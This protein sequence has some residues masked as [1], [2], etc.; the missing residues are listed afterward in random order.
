MQINEIIAKG[1]DLIREGRL[2]EAQEQF[3]LVLQYDP[4]NKEAHN[5]LGF[6][7]F[8]QGYPE[9][10]LLYFRNA[11]AIDPLYMDALLNY[12]HILRS[13]NW[14]PHAVPVLKKAVALDPECAELQALLGEASAETGGDEDVKTVSRPGAGPTVRP[15]RV[16]HLPLI[17]ANNAITLSKH[18]QHLGVES[19]VIS[20]FRTW[21]GYRG[22]F[23]LDLDDLD[24]VERQRRVRTFV[25]DFLDHEAHKYDIFHFHFFD[26]LSTGTSLGG[27]KSHPERDDFWDLERIKGMGKRI[28]VSSWGSDVRNN[29]KLVY[30]QLKYEDPDIQLPYPPLN[31][32]EQY[33][34]IWKFAQYADAMVHGDYETINHTPWGMMI[35]I[36]LDLEPFD[37]LLKNHP[38]KSDRMSILYAP[39][40]QFYKGT[41]YAEALLK[42]ITACYGDAVEIR[43]IHGLPYEEAIKRYVGWGAAIDDIASFSFGLF[44]LEAMY[45]GRTVFTTLRKEEYFGDDMKLKAPIV[46]VY[47]EE[48]FYKKM[49]R[50]IDGDNRDLL[51]SYQT[52][53][54]ERCAASVIARRYQVL[55]EQLMAGERIEQF[56]SQA[57]NRE[58]NNFINGQKVDVRDYYPKVTDILLK[59]KDYGKLMHE[60]EM[61]MGLSNDGDLV[62]KYIFAKEATDQGD[63]ALNLRRNNAAFVATAA[64]REYYQRARDLA[65]SSHCP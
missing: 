14:L 34:N 44:T 28:V 40:N 47:N 57:W 5:N 49:V 7:A 32:R 43:K 63:R 18:L 15:I 60:V 59:R 41:A 46:S 45:L 35:P 42:R 39:S 23:N 54:R 56:V 16:I 2:P 64:F 26:S 65:L 48:D 4:E 50:F 1:E 17:I 10:A 20:Y 13:L 51:D 29:S 62:A 36:G 58:F 33:G 31:R 3:L 22:D 8:A 27:W 24:G 52:F 55:Y 37:L 30:Y 11:I 9:K 53:I 21:L 61:G 19:R 6:I 12:C 38:G 25:E